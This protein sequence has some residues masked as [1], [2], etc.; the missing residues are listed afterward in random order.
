MIVDI[1]ACPTM[2]EADGINE[3]EG[4][5]TEDSKRKKKTKNLIKS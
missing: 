5:I 1:P 3:M 2:V 4:M